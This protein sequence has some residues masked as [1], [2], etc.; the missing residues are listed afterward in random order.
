MVIWLK[1]LITITMSTQEEANSPVSARDD[2]QRKWKT[3]ETARP[4]VADIMFY[5]LL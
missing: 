1:I 4:Y 3:N 2:A 5:K